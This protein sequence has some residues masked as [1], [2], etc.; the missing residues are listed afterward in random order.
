MSSCFALAT[1]VPVINW[2]PPL[3]KANMNCVSFLLKITKGALC[4]VL[5]VHVAAAVLVL[6]SVIIILML[7]LI[8]LVTAS[9]CALSHTHHITKFDSRC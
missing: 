9:L 8:S 6:L 7:D 2:P 4:I 1:S 3:N 5:V